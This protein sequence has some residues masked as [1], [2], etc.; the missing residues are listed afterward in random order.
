MAA[1]KTVQH[2][3]KISVSSK[4]AWQKRKDN[5]EKPEPVNVNNN[6][7][8][9][10]YFDDGLKKC[11]IDFSVRMMEIEKKHP[12]P[13]N[14]EI[15]THDNYDERFTA[16]ESARKYTFERIKKLIAGGENAT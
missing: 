14:A 16:I 10:S 9:R 4:K 5:G 6:V 2:K 3:E 13:I 11:L 12:Y 1:E 7:R 8:I 15:L